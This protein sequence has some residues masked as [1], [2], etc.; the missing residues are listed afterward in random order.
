M[1]FVFV[2]TRLFGRFQNLAFGKIDALERGWVVL[3]EYFFHACIQP[4]SCAMSAR[5]RNYETLP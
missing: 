3:V 5:E 1:P 4:V 2:E